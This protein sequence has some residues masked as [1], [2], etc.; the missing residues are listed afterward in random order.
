MSMEDDDLLDLVPA[1]TLRDFR[2]TVMI[3]I[4]FD[5]AVTDFAADVSCQLH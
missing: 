5:S 4:L 1:D 3:K 2:D